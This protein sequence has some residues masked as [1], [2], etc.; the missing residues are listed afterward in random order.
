MD[1]LVALD[2]DACVVKM[3]VRGR[4]NVVPGI[5]VAVAFIAGALLFA[6]LGWFRAHLPFS[7]ERYLVVTIPASLAPWVLPGM[8]VG[9][10]VS[11]RAVLLGAI[12][13]MVTGAALALWQDRGID[14]FVLKD[15]AIKGGWGILFCGAGA[16]IGTR[17]HLGSS[18]S[19]NRL[20]RSRVASSVSQGGSR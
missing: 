8:L 11:R 17:L 6:L 14:Y 2:H 3:L 12:L 19:N 20:E 5:K 18:S 16:W 10:L 9:L 13:G 7:A 15:V 4:P 1:L